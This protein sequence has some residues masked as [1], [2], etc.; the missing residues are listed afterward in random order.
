MVKL[1]VQ[2]KF[3]QYMALLYGPYSRERIRQIMEP[4][5][6]F[7]RAGFEALIGS[8]IERPD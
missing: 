4:M 2:M 5:Q 8:K 1:V 7:T 6:E 3:A